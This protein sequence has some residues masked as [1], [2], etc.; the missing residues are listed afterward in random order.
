MAL[1]IDVNIPIGQ[2][3]R[4]IWRAGGAHLVNV[5]LFDYYR[6]EQVAKDKKSIAFSLTFSSKERTLDENDIQQAIQ[7]ILAHLKSLFAAELR[8]K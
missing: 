6:G 5:H 2:I 4:E 1:V 8:L 7:K 3:E